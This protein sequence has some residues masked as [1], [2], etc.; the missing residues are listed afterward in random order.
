MRR[1]REGGRR[2]AP[3]TTP[4]WSAAATTGWSR[5]PTWPGRASARSSARRRDVVGGAA[6]TEQ[7]CGPGLQGDDRCPT[8]SACCRPPLVRDLDLD[9]HG[10]HVYPAG[11][12][13][14]ALRPTAATCSCP[15]TRQRRRERD[16]QVLRQGRRRRSSAGTPGWHG[17][18]DV[19][20]PLLYGG[21]AQ[22]R[23]A[24][25]PADLAAPGR[26]CSGGCASARRPQ[27]SPTSPGCS[28]CSIADLLED[29]FESPELQGVLSVSGVIGTWAG[30]RARRHRLRHGPPP[31]R[32]RRRRQARLLG[33]PEGGMG[34]VTQAMAAPPRSFGAEIRTE[35]PVAAH[36]HQR[37]RAS[38]ASSLEDGEELPPRRSSSPPRTRRSPSSQHARPAPSC[39]AD[40]VDDIERWNTRSGTVKVNLAVDRLPEFT[41]KPGFDPEVHGGTI[42]LAESLD[43][44]E[45]AFQDAVAGRPAARAVRRH[46]HPLGVRP[47]AGARGPPHR[48]DVHPVG[49]P[50]WAG[51]PMDAELEAYADRVVAR[52]GARSRPASPTRSCTAR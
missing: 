21:P 11:P 35:A 33:L 18:A 48:L 49:A 10:Y 44:I 34:G 26:R 40:F 47:D 12:V 43:E 19:L 20:G 3:G 41:S 22:A 37:R 17:L 51:K 30:P 6:V 8:W 2:W 38:R 39:P 1:C 27:A 46:L 13:L 24:G 50:H 52:D 4:S 28:P 16:R 29:Y 5:P 23:L 31:H 25:S 9:R 42:V 7:P 15:T 45:S 32:R 14:R 36:H